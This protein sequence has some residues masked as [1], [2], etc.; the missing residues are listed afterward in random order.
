[1][2]E[3][4]ISTSQLAFPSNTLISDYKINFQKDYLFFLRGNF[5]VQFFLF[6]LK[7]ALIKF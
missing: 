1:M 6:Q 4:K 5:D 2:R 3:I 7:V